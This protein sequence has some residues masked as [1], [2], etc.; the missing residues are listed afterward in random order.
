MKPLALCGLL[1]CVI[2]MLTLRNA[3]FTGNAAVVSGG[4][5][6][7]GGFEVSSEV[8]SC[9]SAVP[10]ILEGLEQLQISRLLINQRPCH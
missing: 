3:N 8:S 6:L 4:G 7:L 10:L 1:V 9:K 5:M 2:Q